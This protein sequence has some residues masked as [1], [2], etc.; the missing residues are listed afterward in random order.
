MPSGLRVLTSELDDVPSAVEIVPEFEAVTA[1]AVVVV[2][3]MAVLIGTEVALP[4]TANVPTVVLME[5]DDDP[6]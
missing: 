2:P 5:A 3:D 4:E 1:K 6:E